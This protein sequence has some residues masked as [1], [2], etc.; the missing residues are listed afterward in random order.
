MT[1]DIYLLKHTRTIDRISEKFLQILYI[2]FFSVNLHFMDLII[3]ED[4]LRVENTIH[5]KSNLKD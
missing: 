5:R 4:L 1:L 2:Y 3:Q